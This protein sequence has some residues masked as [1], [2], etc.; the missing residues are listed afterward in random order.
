[1]TNPPIIESLME[2]DFAYYNKGTS[3][4]SDAAY[5]ALRKK[6]L[7]EFPLHQYFSAV[8]SEPLAHLNKVKLHMHMGS[9]NKATSIEEMQAWFD[10][11]WQGAELIVTDKCDGASVELTY[12][13][14]RLVRAATRGDGAIGSDITRNAMKWQDVPHFIEDAPPLMVVRGEALISKPD[15]EQHFKGDVNARNSA[16]ATIQRKD[17]AKNEHIRF[18]AFDAEGTG[19][20]FMFNTDASLFNWLSTKSFI[21]VPRVVV[22]SWDALLELRRDYVNVRPDLAYQIDGMIVAIND[23]AKRK[24][25]GYVNNNTR[26]V[27][28]IAWK[29]ENETAFTELVGIELQV[30]YTGAV[31]PTGILK[32]VVCCGVTVTRATLNNAG[33]VR[34]MGINIGDTVLVER[35]GD[36]IPSIIEVET[37]HSQG[38]YEFPTE[39]PCCKQTLSVELRHVRCTNDECEDR[40][41]GRVMTW[42]RKLNILQ[43]G[44]VVLT[45][46][47]DGEHPLVRDIPDLYALKTAELAELQV[48]NGV[49]GKSMAGKIQKEINK[50]RILSADMFMGSL[51]IKH[52]GRSTARKLGLPNPRAYLEITA[53]A[54]S[55]LEGMGPI[56]PGEIVA[57]I[58]KRRPLIDAL[59]EIIDVKDFVKPEVPTDG[60]LSGMTFCLTGTRMHEKEKVAFINAGGS[61]VGSVVKNLSYLVAAD[62]NANSGKLKKARAQG[63]PVISI[64]EFFQMFITPVEV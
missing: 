23:R 57:S 6:A 26:P 51:G 32:P 27:G 41:Y 2:A 52:L 10:K 18:L 5:D 28:S 33:F 20:E 55:E 4:M 17:G 45:Q 35:S 54:L 19:I 62:V 9:Q 59:L 46:L 47:M 1:M 25:L 34:D 48:G 11:H 53:E 13:V 31:V 8:G 58:A 56:K 39:C 43:L 37:K 49:L 21:P 3:G 24:S 38:A 50:T 40:T 14:G 30:G 29:F 61:E 16:S 60:K 64:E 12:A 15:F 36:V 42:V 63:T 7:E 44:E 22:T